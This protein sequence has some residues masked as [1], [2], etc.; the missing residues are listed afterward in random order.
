MAENSGFFNAIET[1]GVYDRVYDASDFAKLFSLFMTNGVFVNPADQLKVVAKSGLTVT[2]KAGRAFIDGYWYELTEDTTI[3][4]SSN[5]SAYPIN[6]VVT[7]KLD[8]GKRTIKIDKRDAVVSTN[9]VNTDT[10]HEL[11]LAVIA[12]GVGVSTITNAN[13]TDTRANNN[14]CGFVT[15]AVKQIETTDLF[16]QFEDAFG[17]WFKKMK[18][19]LSKDAAG[20]LQNQID[21]MSIQDYY[22]LD[23]IPVTINNTSATD[24]ATFL[25]GSVGGIV[26]GGLTDGIY[27]VSIALK[28]I[29]GTAPFEGKVANVKASITKKQSIITDGSQQVDVTV[30]SYE[31]STVIASNGTVLITFVLPLKIANDNT[32]VVRVSDIGGNSATLSNANSLIYDVTA[33]FE[34]FLSDY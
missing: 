9:P 20:N 11:V 22:S 1:A 33:T 28:W 7:C 15:G 32:L 27:C 26:I 17:A 29:S 30:R 24:K 13:I 31:T 8:K 10:V 21:S 23:K 2:V 5:T 34:K 6:S 12:I 19:Q 3:T 4:M 16:N 25:L 18:D 14:Y